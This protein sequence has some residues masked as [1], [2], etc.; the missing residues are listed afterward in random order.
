[1]E[2]LPHGSLEAL[3]TFSNNSFPRLQC[4]PAVKR[5]HELEILDHLMHKVISLL[6]AC[7]FHPN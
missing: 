1:M 6:Y 4:T 7:T 5:L 3:V 2:T